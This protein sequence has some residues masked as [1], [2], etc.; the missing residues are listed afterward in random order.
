MAARLIRI[1]SGNIGRHGNAYEVSSL[2]DEWFWAAVICAVPF[3]AFGALEVAAIRKRRRHE[4]LARR[5]KAAAPRQG[6]I[7]SRAGKATRRTH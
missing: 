4:A 2:S 7:A 3:L 1:K 5:S 6:R